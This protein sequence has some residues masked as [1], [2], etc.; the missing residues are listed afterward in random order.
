[1]S[2]EFASPTAIFATPAKAGGSNLE[3]RR[4]VRKDDLIMCRRNSD[5]MIPAGAS[6]VVLFGLII[7]DDVG[8]VITIE[9]SKYLTEVAFALSH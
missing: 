1:L 4:S 6:L 5:E 9:K 2:N 3:G 8:E 7:V